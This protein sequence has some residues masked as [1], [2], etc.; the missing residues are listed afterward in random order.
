MEIFQKIKEIA[1]ANP[2]GFTISIL[3]FKA[4]EKGFCVAMKETQNCF[5]DEGL[6]KA[7]K[8]A[9]QTTNIVGG[10]LDKENDLFYYDAI[11]IV[12]DLETAL[13]LAK[14]NK[15]IAIF[16]LETEIRM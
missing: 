4:Q 8:I 11:M 3:D 16:D 14:E 10:W 5:N 12:E 2:N 6:K 1:E 15:Q 7:I 13:K 9:K